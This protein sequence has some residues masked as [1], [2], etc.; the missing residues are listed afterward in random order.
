MLHNQQIP[1][2]KNIRAVKKMSHIYDFD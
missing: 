2:N 1:S